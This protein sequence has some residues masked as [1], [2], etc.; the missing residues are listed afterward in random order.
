MIRIASFHAAGCAWLLVL[1]TGCV[2]E[3]EGLP[4]APPMLPQTL[5]AYERMA[6]FAEGDS[7]ARLRGFDGAA[8]A[9]ATLEVRARDG[10]VLVQVT[11]DESGRFDVHFTAQQDAL[12][13]LHAHLGTEEATPLDFTVRSRTAALDKLVVDRLAGTGSTPNRIV[14][15]R[16]APVTGASMALVVL[17]G[18]NALDNINADD[19][20]RMAPLVP[21]METS[22]PF[23]PVMA[24]PWSV[25]A[26]D[27][28]AIVTRYMQGGVTAVSLDK[29]RILGE[30]APDRPV[31][32]P[33]P[34][35]LDP[36]A[37][38]TGDGHA[39]SDINELTPRTP[40]DVAVVGKRAF[41][42]YAN[43]LSQDHTGK[44]Q[45][46][47]GM[48]VIH[49]LDD[50]GVPTGTNHVRVLSFVNPQHVVASPDGAWVVVASTGELQ[51]TSAGWNVVSDGGLDVFDART[52][53][54]VRTISMS[55]FAP[56]RPVWLPNGKDVYV[57]SVLRARLSRVDVMS[58]DIKRGSAD[59]IMLEESDALRTVFEC[60]LHLTGLVF[61]GIFDTDQLVVVDSADDTVGPWPFVD[62]IPLPGAS[63]SMGGGVQSL[64]V[65]PGRNGV[66]RNG[67]DVLV[68]LSLATRVAAL[69]TRYVLGP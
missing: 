6:L 15:A 35:H 28:V 38:V 21:F 31:A 7:Q 60:G 19:G 12:L 27:G 41:T 67:F 48:L 1:L 63:G 53:E 29:G 14:F 45:F 16:D 61:C 23:G 22:G 42:A 3:E 25:D 66:D 8:P 68:L 5:V 69:D 64:A 36:A 54:R 43:V 4:P 9:G 33:S 49:E 20:K 56:S 2:Q 51:R 57:P 17:S 52:M 32:L 50:H 11:A 59:P 58:G 37:D 39:E 46:G 26:K 30:A 65:R 18:D 62:A 55:R 13:T 47:P 10:S 40:T 34:L 24:N 44:A